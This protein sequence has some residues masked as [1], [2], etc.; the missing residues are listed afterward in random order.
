MFHF[1]MVILTTTSSPADVRPRVVSMCMHLLMIVDEKPSAL[2]NARAHGV[3]KR[4]HAAAERNLAQVAYDGSIKTAR[5]PDDPGTS[6]PGD[7]LAPAA[8]IDRL[9]ALMVDLHDP[10]VAKTLLFVSGPELMREVTT[11]LRDRSRELDLQLQPYLDGDTPAGDAATRNAVLDIVPA[12]DDAFYHYGT[13]VG[14]PPSFL[15]YLNHMTD[16]TN[17]DLYDVVKAAE[18]ARD[19]S[20][21]GDLLL[22]DQ[23]V[24]RKPG[25]PGYTYLAVVRVR[26]RANESGTIH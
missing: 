25:A 22:F 26:R 18:F 4:A 24:Y 15:G 12:A 3:V 23:L 11:T 16:Q 6:G 10:G 5:H 19:E 1:L 21:G 9:N 2:V 20:D 7:G 17:F 13:A 14:V 8:S